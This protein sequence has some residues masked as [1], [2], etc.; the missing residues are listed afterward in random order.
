MR[1]TRRT[2]RHDKRAHPRI[3]VE[4]PVSCERRDGPPVLGTLRDISIGGA[5]VESA[6]ALPF[7]T[8]LVIVGRLPNAKADLRLPSIV[9]WAKPDGFG[10]QFASLGAR[11][12]HAILTGLK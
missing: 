10:V 5:F 8:A 11:E 7:G 12:T 4:I 6:E 3:A 1:S 2:A 9:R